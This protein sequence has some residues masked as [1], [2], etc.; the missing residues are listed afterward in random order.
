MTRRNKSKD[1]IV[2]EMKHKDNVAHI[3]DVVGKIFPLLKVDTIYDAQTVVNA[4]SGFI[5]AHTEAK[6]KEIKLNEVTID[7]SKEDESKI[8]TS[9]LAIIDLMKDE[10]AK[11]LS[12][13]LERLGKTFSQYGSH[14]FLKKPMSAISI[15]NILA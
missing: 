14:E 8:K 13:I 4:L 10:G 2:E 5:M 7:L 11:E 15:D 12:E 6:L 1:Q 3:K 9:M